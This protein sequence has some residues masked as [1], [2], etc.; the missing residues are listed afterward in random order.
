MYMHIQPA[1]DEIQAPTRQIDI[2]N[3]YTYTQGCLSAST[4]GPSSE[5]D[6]KIHTYTTNA[7]ILKATSQRQ[8]AQ[9]P[10]YWSRRRRRCHPIYT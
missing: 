7:H 6:K 3:K 9:A 10:N 4:D 2:Y 8:R 5:H 1:R